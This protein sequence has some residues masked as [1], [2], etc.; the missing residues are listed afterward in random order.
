MSDKI[1]IGIFDN[2]E[3]ATHAVELLRQAEFEAKDISVLGADPD[4]LRMVAVDLESKR[5]DSVVTTCGIIGALGGFT[6]G[7]ATLAI[8]GVGA[9]LAAGPLMAAI[10]GAAAG[11]MLGIIAGGL[12][13][14]DVPEY[15]ANVYE[16]HLTQGKVLVSVHTDQH[17]LRVLAEDIFEE[18][19]AFEIST[20]A[21]Q[22]KE[23]VAV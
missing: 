3:Q 8:P 15:D 23:T 18:C 12:I 14:F 20:K 1:V 6:V 5:P 21:S 11:G 4:E 13:H 7:L 2:Y 19:E 16:T 22:E 17:D 9:F 10:S